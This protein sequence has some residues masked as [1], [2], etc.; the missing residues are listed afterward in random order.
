MQHANKLVHG[1]WSPEECKKSSTW[2]EVE[3]VR[4][5]LEEIAPL[6]MGLCVKRCTEFHLEGSRG[7]KKGFRGDCPTPDGSLCEMVH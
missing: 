2:R 1:S 4:R 5:V 3:A 6:L 7:S